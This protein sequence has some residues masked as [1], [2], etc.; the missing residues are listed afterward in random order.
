MNICSAEEGKKQM[1]T[2]RETQISRVEAERLRRE[3]LNHR[4]NELR[5]V[6][7][8]VSKMDRASVLTDAVAYIKQLE[9]QRE[10]LEAQVGVESQTAAK[11]CVGS[12]SIAGGHHAVPSLGE[13]EVMIVG[14]EAMIR[15]QCV[16]V[17]YPCARLMEAL[18]ELEIEVYHASMTKVKEIMLQ[19]VVVRVPKGLTSEE[20]LTT[21]I[22]RRFQI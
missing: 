5:S 9:A 1:I 19:D 3:K 12:S 21:A 8:N 4:F 17:N 13:V 15:V 14:S 22:H 16:D 6:V 20:A 10:E 18:R 2:A 7:P 11:A